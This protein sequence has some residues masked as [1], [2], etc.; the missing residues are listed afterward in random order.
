MCVA[1][2]TMGAFAFIGFNALIGKYRIY[3]PGERFTVG[4]TYEYTI[5]EYV[6]KRW[7]EWFVDDEHKTTSAEFSLKARILTDVSR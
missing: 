5:K 2:A 4:G 3:E 7:R 6:R 1:L